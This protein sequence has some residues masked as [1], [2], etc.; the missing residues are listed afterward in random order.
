MG[1]YNS[2]LNLGCFCDSFQPVEYSKSVSALA[3]ERH[4]EEAISFKF[5]LLSTL[6]LELLSHHERNLIILRETAEDVTGRSSGLHFQPSSY[7]Y[8]MPDM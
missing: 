1:V 5:L 7:L 6:S 8:H 3:S 2:F 4:T